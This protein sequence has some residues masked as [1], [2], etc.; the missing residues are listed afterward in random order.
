MCGTILL[1]SYEAVLIY[2]T[3]GSF[4]GYGIRGQNK[5]QSTN[6]WIED[7]LNSLNTRLAELNQGSNIKAYWPHPQDPEVVALLNDP[8]FHPIEYVDSE[9]IDE[10]KSYLVFEQIETRDIDGNPTGHFEEGDLIPEQSY[11][12]TKTVQVPARPSDVK[13]R[14]QDAMETIA[15]QRANRTAG[16]T[17][18]QLSV[19]DSPI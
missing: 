14:L 8:E 1:M 4:I 5:L 16:F 3:T 19:L 13:L 10:E 9:A 17:N 18:T 2:N 6:I 15:K 11:I 12:V 7:E